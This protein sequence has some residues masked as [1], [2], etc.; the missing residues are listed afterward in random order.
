[1]FTSKIAYTESSES[2]P[3]SHPEY[4]SGRCP[5]VEGGSP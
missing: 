3:Q 2:G 5:P 4:F 1:M